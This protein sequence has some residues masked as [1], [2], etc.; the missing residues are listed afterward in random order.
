M[1]IKT[2]YE[3]IVLYTEYKSNN[4]YSSKP[5]VLYSKTNQTLR[6]ML[7]VQKMGYW[8]YVFWYSCNIYSKIYQYC[9]SDEI[10]KKTTD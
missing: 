5:Y 8:S 1:S 3:V 10:T 2:Q 4:N 9:T 6:L 7:F